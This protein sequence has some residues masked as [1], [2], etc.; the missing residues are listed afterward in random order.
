MPSPP[1]APTLVITNQPLVQPEFKP[2]LSSVASPGVSPVVPTAAPALPQAATPPP[3]VGGPTVEPSVIPPGV[4][5]SSPPLVDAH[6]HLTNLPAT[7]PPEETIPAGTIDWVGAGGADL[8]QVFEYYAKLTGRTILRPANLAAPPIKLRTESDLTRREFIQALDSVLAMN[9]IA[10]IPMGEKF[11]KAVPIAQANQEGAAIQRLDAELLPELGSY[12]T[13]IVQ[14]KYAKPSELVQVLTPFAKVPNGILPIDSNQILVLRDNAENVKRMLELIREIDVAV[15]SE[16]ISEVIPI[17]YAMAS[18]IAAALNSLSA[19][20]GTTSVGARATGATRAQS[21]GLQRPGTTGLPGQ[22]MTTPPGAQPPQANPQANFSQRLQQIVQRASA[23]ASGEI[24]VI[25][26]TKIIAD[27]RANALL[28]YAT[29]EDMATIKDIISKLDVILPQVL[30]ETTILDVSLNNKWNLGLSGLQT[31]RR[32]GDNIIGAGGVNAS[33]A[34]NFSGTNLTADLLGS[35]LRYFTRI[36]DNFYLTLQAAASDGTARVIQ[37]PRILTSHAKPA[38]FFVGETVPYITSTY[39]GGWGTGPAASYQQ[40][41]VGIQL[42]VT[43]FINADGLVLMQIDQSIDELGD[44]VEIAGGGKVPKTRSR[45][46]SAE[47][48]VR[49]GE[50][51]LL[52]GYIRSSGTESH[53]GV[54]VLKDIPLLGYLFRSNDRSRDRSELMVLMRP[55]VLMDPEEA[56]RLSAEERQRLPGVRRAEREFNHEENLY[57]ERQERRT[58]APNAESNHLPPPLPAATA[59]PAAN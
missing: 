34:F 46:L 9:G 49:N 17:K 32:L 11:V 8:E 43:P 27:E 10:M 5:P 52:G 7:P 33:Q 24:Q 37:K 40:L 26:Q 19:G 51:I 50:S 54:P 56:A 39:Y 45:T 23:L 12:V 53:A 59:A 42:S 35:G 48:A 14:L 21:A 2:P 47:V 6:R 15:P 36:D 25:G 16:Y 3:P 31:T 38:S 28:V 55:V 41:R 4:I 57:R 29:K 13:H 18:D 44:E 58:R 20:G 1:S 30:I 22:P